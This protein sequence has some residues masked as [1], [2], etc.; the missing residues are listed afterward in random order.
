MTGDIKWKEE[1]ERKK[2]SK[3]SGK[4]V[5]NK[6]EKNTEKQHQKRNN[7]QRE[8]WKMGRGE[9]KHRERWET[10]IRMRE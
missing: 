7:E 2:E 1:K 5:K 9:D 4:K 8:F 6:E 10:K 3:K